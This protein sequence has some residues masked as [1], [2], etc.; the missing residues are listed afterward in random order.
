MLRAARINIFSACL[1]FL[2]AP[3]AQAGLIL[4]L[5]SPSIAG[6]PGQ[7]FTL[8]GSI[9]HLDPSE[10]L[11][12]I[13]SFNFTSS[14][15]QL[16]SI[17]APNSVPYPAGYSGNILTVQILLG[18][19]TG[20]YPSNSFSLTYDSINGRTFSTNSVNLAVDVQS[21]VPEPGTFLLTLASLACLGI[22][23]TTRRRNLR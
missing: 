6:T 8:T 11:A 3:A 13:Q 22:V 15:L 7:I 4:A 14:V 12:S 9:A 17:D 1:A 20:S 18:A 2:F 21:A 19:L 5:D 10:D 16:L 23:R